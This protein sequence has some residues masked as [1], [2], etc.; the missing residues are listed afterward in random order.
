MDPFSGEEDQSIAA[1]LAQLFDD[2]ME[3]HRDRIRLGRWKVELW[4]DEPTIDE[5]GH[6]IAGYIGIFNHPIDREWIKKHFGGGVYHVTLR[7]PSPKGT[8]KIVARKNLNG[9]EIAGD[10]IPSRNDGHYLGKDGEEA[11]K[12]HGHLHQRL[13]AVR[14]PAEDD[15]ELD[16]ELDEEE[17]EVPRPYPY[18]PGM[19]AMP[20]GEH[21]DMIVKHQLDMSKQL[22]QRTW[23]LEDRARKGDAGDEKRLERLFRELQDGNSAALDRM[24]ELV[25][26]Q[27]ADSKAAMQMVEHLSG[28]LAKAEEQRASD[29]QALTK[30]HD[31]MLQSQ[32]SLWEEE[33]KA[34]RVDAREARD[35]GLEA[36]REEVKRKEDQFES[37]RRRWEDERKRLNEDA[38]RDAEDWR[39]RLDDA[40]E[41]AAA[42]LKEEQRRG[43]ARAVTLKDNHEALMATTI[44]NYE[45]RI[46]G[47]EDRLA[48]AEGRSTTLTDELAQKRDDLQAERVN[49]ATAKQDAKIA[50]MA[51]RAEANDIGTVTGTIGKLTGFAEQMGWKKAA[52]AEDEGSAVTK[53]IGKGA[54][55]AREVMQNREFRDLMEATAD[56]IKKGTEAAMQNPAQDQSQQ[57]QQDQSQQLNQQAWN[58]WQ[59]ASRQQDQTQV[60]QQPSTEEARQLQAAQ[61][62]ARAAAEAEEAARLAQAQ[63][64]ARANAPD[65]MQPPVGENGKPELT[66]ELIVEEIERAC[67]QGV[68]PGQF[69][70]AFLNALGFSRAEARIF[71]KDMTAEQLGE[72]VG[73]TPGMLSM[74]AEDYFRLVLADL[75]AHP[76]E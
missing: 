45:A 73:V 34:L 54:D 23:D 67:E 53:V 13:G 43:E 15:E 35:K 52:G 30:Q 70:D 28:L 37:E 59:Q 36:G 10:P 18:H 56:R 11:L 14:R 31:E 4:R 60:Q 65:P 76:T 64:Q 41:R 7:G 12:R 3:E 63:E 32:K 27:P 17:E 6:R 25:R 33:L 57:P 68:P 48:Q 69:A 61:Q 19:P 75:K 55:V 72:Q 49:L 40:R 66:P 38:R 22:M 44:S 20:A 24:I 29:R 71:L 42:D 46:K 51:A 58:A 47:L 21:G 39:R 2:A 26:E 9:I 1:K 8:G 50:E 62:A 5:V 74:D 16:E